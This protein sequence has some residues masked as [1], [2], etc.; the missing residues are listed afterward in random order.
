VLK[1]WRAAQHKAA[2][3][4]THVQELP[5]FGQQPKHGIGTVE[6]ESTKP[7]K[8]K[9]LRPLRSIASVGCVIEATLCV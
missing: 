9:I 5:V 2:V 4:A 8:E 7:A 1:K 6:L 3:P